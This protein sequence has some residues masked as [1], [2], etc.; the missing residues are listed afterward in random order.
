MFRTRLISGIVLVALA[1]L[2]IGCG[3][4]VLLVSTL[5]LSLIGV[6]ELQRAIGFEKK[7]PAIVSLIWTVV[8]YILLRFTGLHYFVLALIIFLIIDLATYVFAYPK[9]SSKEIFS[10]FFSFSY[11]SVM[12][13]FIYLTREI[14]PE[15]QYLVWLIFITAWGCDTCAYCVG[16]LFGRHKMAPVLS[17][18]KSIEGGVGGVVGASL[19]NIL[20][21]YI[22]RSSLNM[23]TR[24]ILLMGAA[25]AVGALVS[26]VGDLAAS[27]IKR[28]HDIKDY[29][30]LIPGHGGVLDR[31][32]SIIITAPVV[33]FLSLIMVR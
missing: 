1:L 5:I 33:Y 3:G 9:F 26:M 29:G 12:L 14:K 21:C 10:S 6:F 22:F 17:P 31:F 18:K 2:L 7:A 4:D 13:S 8:Y 30:K 28:D 11:V 16:R 15:G 25:G 19:L 23:G 20:Y 27:A 32:D 24:E